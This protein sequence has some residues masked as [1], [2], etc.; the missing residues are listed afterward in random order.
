MKFKPKL[1]TDKILEVLGFL[2]PSIVMEAKVEG[3]S[4]WYELYGTMPDQY[5]QCRRKSS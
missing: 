1:E 3:D 4:R 2:D 5:K